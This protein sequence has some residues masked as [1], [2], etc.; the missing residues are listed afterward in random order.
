MTRGISPDGK[1]IVVTDQN[2]EGYAAF[3]RHADGSP[4]VRLGEGDGF[5]L[6]PD[7]KWVLALTSAPPRRLVLHPTGTGSSRELP[8]PDQIEPEQ[9]RW[10][11]DGR[12]V[13][14]ARAAGQRLRRGFVL[15]PRTD[16]RPRA[17][18]EEGVE[19]VRY[20]TIPAS[21]DGRRVV[22]RDL[23]GRVAAF[24]IDGGAPE[25]IAGLGADDIPLEWTADGR[26]LFVARQGELPWR[27]RRH[28]LAGGRDTPWMEV[29]PGQVAGARLSMLFLT[30]D[31][32]Y[33]AH[34]YSRMLVD[35][36]EATGLR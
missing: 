6:S 18:T 27:V 23:E 36:Y 29:A 9:P 13:M 10:L 14:F 31:G 1:T 16:A 34:G 15:D 4:P 22:A 8:N 21:P 19:P 17:F 20:W 3:I 33:W 26:A 11:P 12:I 32:R 24:P 28:E 5:G 7:G 2:I 30:P 25:P 35:L